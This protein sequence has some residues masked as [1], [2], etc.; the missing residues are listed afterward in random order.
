VAWGC[1]LLL[2]GLRT[3]LGKI[4][5][6]DVLLV[7]ASVPLLLAGRVTPEESEPPGAEASARTALNAAAAIVLVSYVSAAWWKLLRNGPGWALSDNLRW[8]LAAG[9]EGSHSPKLSTW[10]VEHPAACIVLACG[11]LG[12]ELGAA[13]VWLQPRLVPAFLAAATLMHAGTW[14]VLGLDYWAH[15]AMVAL[16]LLPWAS[17]RRR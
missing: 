13:L 10:L 9:R 2:A 8:A 3:S 6:N 1:L 5:H 17:M 14:V 15:L 4:L 12:L 16:V 7:V 11:I